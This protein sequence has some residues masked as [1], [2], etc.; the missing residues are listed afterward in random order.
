[1]HSGNYTDPTALNELSCPGK[2][3]LFMTA[4]QEE[5]YFMVLQETDKSGD[6]RLV[7]CF[8]CARLSLCSP[9]APASWVYRWLPRES[10]AK[11][12]NPGKTVEH[13]AVTPA[14]SLADIKSHFNDAA[15][16]FKSSNI[17]EAFLPGSGS[18]TIRNFLFLA[19]SI[20]ASKEMSGDLLSWLAS[21]KDPKFL[22][23]FQEILLRRSASFHPKV[24]EDK[25]CLV[26]NDIEWRDLYDT[27]HAFVEKLS[28]R[29]SFQF[30]YQED[31]SE[32]GRW[33]YS[34]RPHVPEKSDSNENE[35]TLALRPEEEGDDTEYGKLWPQKVYDEL[36]LDLKFQK[37]CII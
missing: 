32:S 29:W 20:I 24:H 26:I 7:V 25:V 11:A 1:M 2:K 12:L 3:H 28:Y 37:V 6:F 34:V 35:L 23:L 10:H 4:T 18:L 13:Y 16:F 30:I 21:S 8:Y 31:E 17:L 14:Q 22:E 33:S 15:P 9:W 5:E 19:Q 27:Y 36:D